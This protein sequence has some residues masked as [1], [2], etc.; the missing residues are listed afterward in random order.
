VLV[1]QLDAI[2]R[3]APRLPDACRQALSVKRTQSWKTRARW[4]RL[5]AA[6][7]MR[8][9]TGHTP[10]SKCAANRACGPRRDTRGNNGDLE[11]LFLQ[12]NQQR[13][14]PSAGEQRPDCGMRVSKARE[15][16]GPRS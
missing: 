1:R 13:D 5:I 12:A 14:F 16:E 3:L 11:G 2:R 4:S 6:T 10:R 7:A 8:R 9:G 15:S